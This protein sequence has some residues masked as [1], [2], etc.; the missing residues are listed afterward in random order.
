[1]NRPGTEPRCLGPLAKLINQIIC[2][3]PHQTAEYT[4]KLFLRWIQAQG[5]S[6]DT[7]GI[8]LNASGPVGISLKRDTS[9]ARQ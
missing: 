6:P 7:P 5:R 2:R 8:P 1:M 4:P 9:G 3:A